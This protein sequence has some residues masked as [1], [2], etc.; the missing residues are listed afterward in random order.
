MEKE[1]LRKVLDLILEVAAEQA[2]REFSGIG[3]YQDFA[4]R[5]TEIR[6]LLDPQTKQHETGNSQPKAD[7]N[8]K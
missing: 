1:I 5:Y 3:W 2:T 4:A 7:N 8:D 6:E